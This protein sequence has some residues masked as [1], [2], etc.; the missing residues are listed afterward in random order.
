MHEDEDNNLEEV[1]LFGSYN[2]AG[3]INSDYALIIS[4]ATDA[5]RTSRT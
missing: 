5:K 3:D 4:G 2:D 1:T